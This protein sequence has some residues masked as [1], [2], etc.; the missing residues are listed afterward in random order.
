MTDILQAKLEVWKTIIDVQK[1][2]N[3]LEMRI[4]N[5]AVTV[6]AAFLAAAGY[7]MKENL[8]ITLSGSTVTLTSLVLIAGTLCWLA[9]YGMDRFW[10][11]RLLRGAVNQGLV[12]EDSLATDLPEIRLTKAIGDASP[13][14]VFGLTIRSGTKIDIFYLLVAG[15]LLVAAV[16][17]F[18][19]GPQAPER[20]ISPKATGERAATGA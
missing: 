10:Y 13:V 15:L 1:H 3:E 9:F 2:F 6:L 11:H 12:I 4:R 18:V 17:S 20:L 14:Q 16:I 8:H 7:T 5:V 19:Q